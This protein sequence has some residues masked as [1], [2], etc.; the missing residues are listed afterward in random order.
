MSG[1]Q[2][3]QKV[4]RGRGAAPSGEEK[5]AGWNSTTL[6]R[7]FR[8]A[9]SAGGGGIRIATISQRGAERGTDGFLCAIVG[10]L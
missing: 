4:Q 7:A 6:P 9:N 3:C 10:S 5:G 8:A 2:L 1:V